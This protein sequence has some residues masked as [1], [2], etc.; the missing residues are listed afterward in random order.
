MHVC[1]NLPG[2]GTK[3]IFSVRLFDVSEN[4]NQQ[5]KSFDASIRLNTLDVQQLFRFTVYIFFV[6]QQCQRKQLIS[7]K[8]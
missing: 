8:K 2:N 7:I 1:K 5:L 3:V 6:L 4:Y